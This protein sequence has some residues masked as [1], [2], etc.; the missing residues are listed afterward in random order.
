MIG[1]LLSW[2]LRTRIERTV[3]ALQGN[4]FDARAMWGGKAELF[5][6]LDRLVPLSAS[7]GIGGSMTIK[8]LAVADWLITRGNRLYDHSRPGLTPEQSMAIRRQQLTADVFLSG[9]NAVTTDGKLVNID[10]AGNR[11]AAMTFGPQAVVVIVGSNKLVDNVGAGLERIRTVAA[12]LNAKR[13]NKQ[14]PC[15]ATGL[16]S[17]CRSPQR[18]CTTTHIL[19]KKPTTLAFSV[20]IIPDSYGF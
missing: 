18:I 19:D 15:A 1:E 6:V 12:P 11:V 5:E 7:V 2:H 20:L 10:G 14:T 4:N 8:Q 3:E 9:S 16:C 13:L 17:D